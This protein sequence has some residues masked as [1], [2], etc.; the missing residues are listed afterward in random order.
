[1]I[2][3]CN[4]C[5]VVLGH[6]NT[7]MQC[8]KHFMHVCLFL[9][10]D[11]VLWRSL[12]RSVRPSVCVRVCCRANIW[13]PE[14]SCGGAQGGD[15]GLRR[16]LLCRQPQSSCVWGRLRQMEASVATSGCVFVRAAS[17]LLIAGPSS[18]PSWQIIQEPNV[19]VLVYGLYS[20]DVM[21]SSVS[22]WQRCLSVM[23]DKWR[24]Q[25]IFWTKSVVFQLR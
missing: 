6:F 13:A 9:A 8:I 23:V 1:M 2:N 7:E 15:P 21:V 12:W 22:Q 24:F 11:R 16:A 17:L 4:K 14:R 25:T 10:S 18:Q 19:P 5:L 20:R 3:T